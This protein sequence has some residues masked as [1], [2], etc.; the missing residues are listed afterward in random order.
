[1]KPKMRS[2]ESKP[3]KKAGLDIPLWIAFFI[4]LFAGFIANFHFSNID[5]ALRVAAGI[6]L[7]V[8]LIAL[9]L[10]TAQGKKA[11]AF[12]KSARGELRKVVWPT[13][14]ETVQTTLVVVV[15]VIVTAIFLWGVDSLFLWL[16]GLLTG[17]RG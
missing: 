5:W 1:M 14:Q 8:I 15:M 10:Q 12:I 7:V 13:R 2:I 11:W 17:Q 3:L 6:V 9:A 16:I 4:L